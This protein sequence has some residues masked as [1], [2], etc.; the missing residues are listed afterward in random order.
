M[1]LGRVN[2]IIELALNVS[3]A[4]QHS[5]DFDAVVRGLIEDDVALRGKLRRF[6]K[7]SWRGRGPLPG[8]PTGDRTGR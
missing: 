2:Q 8:R 4:V 3:R 1:S 7:R 5:E 6:T